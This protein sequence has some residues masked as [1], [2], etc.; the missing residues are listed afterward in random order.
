MIPGDVID[1]ML[2]QNDIG[3]DKMGR[4]QLEKALGLD[5]PM[6]IAVL[7]AGSAPSCSHGDF[8]RSLWQNTPVSEQLLQR[9]PSPSSSA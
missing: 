7:P 9:L 6:W 1:L 5:Q 2:S 3:A 4:E 8:G